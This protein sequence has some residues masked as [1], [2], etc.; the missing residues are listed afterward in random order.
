MQVR[1]SVKILFNLVKKSHIEPFY[2]DYAKPCR[3]ALFIRRIVEI[4][5]KMFRFIIFFGFVKRAIYDKWSWSIVNFFNFTLYY[6]SMFRLF[7]FLVNIPI[8]TIN[9]N[10]IFKIIKKS[11]FTR[12]IRKPTLLIITDNNKGKFHFIQLLFT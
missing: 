4:I 8:L 7:K 9:D 5:P 12:I 10:F 2:S 6:K 11:L 1:F 3:K